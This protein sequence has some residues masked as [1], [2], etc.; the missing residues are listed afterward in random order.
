MDEIKLT[1]SQDVLYTTWLQEFRRLLD[2]IT[3]VMN[4][5]LSARMKV[6]AQES[7]ID[8]DS[9]E[10]RWDATSKSFRRIVTAPAGNT[11]EIKDAEIVEMPEVK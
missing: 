11:E 6:L 7:G 8:M 5:A 4:E 9:E 2:M 10:W 1:K 3:Q